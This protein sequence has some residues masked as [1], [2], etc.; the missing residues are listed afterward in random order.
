MPSLQYFDDTNAN[1]L[2]QKMD[3]SVF[4]KNCPFSAS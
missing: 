1:Y 3:P 2:F 4:F